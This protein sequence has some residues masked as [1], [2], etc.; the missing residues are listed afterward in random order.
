MQN[1]V[2]VT[3]AQVKTADIPEFRE[4]VAAYWQAL[5]PHAPVIQDPDQREAYFR[6]RFTWTGGNRHPHWALLAG[7]R[8]GFISFEVCEAKRSA[9][10]EDFYIVPA[11]RRK[12]YGSAMMRALYDCLDMLGVELIELNVRR[13]N[14]AALVFWETQGFRIASY[15]LRQYRDPKTGTAFIGA[16]SSDFVGAAESEQGEQ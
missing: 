11:E 3:L 16:L 6:E 8:I 7:Q 10:V 14:P 15:R 13:D 4:M 1:P 9:S 5:M 12:G 2:K